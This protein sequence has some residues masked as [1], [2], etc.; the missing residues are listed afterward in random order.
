MP[1]PNSQSPITLR[2]NELFSTVNAVQR[3]GFID[4]LNTLSLSLAQ[5]AQ[6][7]GIA[8][9]AWEYRHLAAWPAVQQDLVRAVMSRA[10]MSGRTIVFD[11]EESNT[12]TTSVIDFGA[13]QPIGIT[14]RSPQ[15]YPPYS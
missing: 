5:L 2:L 6:S 12:T 9:N 8:R 4:D 7:Y 11:W 14:F 13:R 15:I 1:Y 10:V 3:P